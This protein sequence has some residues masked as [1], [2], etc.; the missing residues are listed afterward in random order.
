MSKDKIKINTLTSFFEYIYYFEWLWCDQT[1]IK[2][3]I[4]DSYLSPI[5]EMLFYLV[6]DSR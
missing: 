2:T 4:N 5:P 1:Q 3:K 6:E